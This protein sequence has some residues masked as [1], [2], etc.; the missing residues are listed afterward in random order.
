MMHCIVN[1]KPVCNGPNM[2]VGV[3]VGEGDGEGVHVVCLHQVYLALLYNE[4]QYLKKISPPH[5]G[6]K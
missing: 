4:L 3:V 5:F 2:M 6:K 1:N